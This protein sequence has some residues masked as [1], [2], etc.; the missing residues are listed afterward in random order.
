MRFHYCRSSRR[1]GHS[2]T[3]RKAGTL[4]LS[5]SSSRRHHQRIRRS[6]AAFLG[7]YRVRYGDRDFV[8]ATAEKRTSDFANRRSVPP[9]VVVVGSDEEGGR[10]SR[11][12][13]SSRR[14]CSTSDNNR[15]KTI[16]PSPGRLIGPHFFCAAVL[17]AVAAAAPPLPPPQII[18]AAVLATIM[19]PSSLLVPSAAVCYYSFWELFLTTLLPSSFLPFKIFHS[20]LCRRLARSTLPRSSTALCSS[21]AP[22]HHTAT[23]GHLVLKRRAPPSPRRTRG[24]VLRCRRICGLILLPPSTRCSNRTRSS[25][26]LL[27][28]TGRLTSTSSSR[29]ALFLHLS[30]APPAG[31]GHASIRS[32]SRGSSPRPSPATVLSGGSGE[33]AA[34]AATQ[35][36]RQRQRLLLRLLLRLS[37][38]VA[39][40]LR[41]FWSVSGGSKARAHAR[42]HRRMHP[43]A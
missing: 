3:D 5:V 42:M 13:S 21:S 43:R 2:R 10:R 12:S 40:M 28:V 33:R 22:A 1:A 36:Q 30:L 16:R 4:Y 17:P 38:T 24:L 23:G 15:I 26:M 20:C 35:Q 6:A 41:T 7:G 34:A 8:G 32:S 39:G 25:A 14:Q 31:H 19:P 9:P 11:C 37:W 18:I 27:F 29:Q